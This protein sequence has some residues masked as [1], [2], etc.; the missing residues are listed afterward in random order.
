MNASGWIRTPFGR[1]LQR[2]FEAA[3]TKDDV[4]QAMRWLLGSKEA[5]ARLSAADLHDLLS[6]AAN[7]PT[8][9]RDDARAAIFT[10][11][12]TFAEGAGQQVEAIACL[13]RALEYHHTRD[14]AA[15]LERLRRRAPPP[16][17]VAV[18]GAK[19]ARLKTGGSGRA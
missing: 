2:R 3:R 17:V 8:L 19:K 1:E 14:R 18:S 5:A 7:A 4:A 12:S 10:T 11:M 13:E 9:V 16:A 15:R 6:F